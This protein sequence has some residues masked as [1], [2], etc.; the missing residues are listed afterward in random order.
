MLLIDFG[1]V[2]DYRRVYTSTVCLDQTDN[3]DGHCSELHQ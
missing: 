3:T 1:F 2:S